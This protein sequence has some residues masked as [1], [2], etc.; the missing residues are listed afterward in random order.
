MKIISCLNRKSEN[1]IIERCEWDELRAPYRNYL[2]LFW[3]R[4]AKTRLPP[5]FAII[6]FRF[7]ARKLNLWYWL[8]Y[9]RMTLKNFR[10]KPEFRWRIHKYLNKINMFSKFEP[11]QLWSIFSGWLQPSLPQTQEVIWQLSPLSPRQPLRSWSCF[12]LQWEGNSSTVHVLYSVYFVL[13]A[14]QE[15]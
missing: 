9:K 1:P 2:S 13:E 12:G 14:V 11:C 7:S 4:I 10:L 15:F 6:N 3:R 8:L 5:T